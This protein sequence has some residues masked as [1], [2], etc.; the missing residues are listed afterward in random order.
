MPSQWVLVG[1]QRICPLVL[2]LRGYSV[3][4]QNGRNILRAAIRLGETD[5]SQRR[6]SMGQNGEKHSPK[7]KEMKAINEFQ[8]WLDRKPAGPKPKKRLPRV[9][10]KRAKQL[11]EYSVR[12]A[13]FKRAN[14]HCQSCGKRTRDVHHT[15]GRGPNLLNE[16]SWMA[17]CRP[18]HRWCHENPGDARAKGW[19]K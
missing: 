8:K 12:A 6:E 19:I 15:L 14:P 9:T 16:S 11:R 7:K 4:E 10:K 3:Y 2:Q 13:A 18:C 5:R 1:C 17:L